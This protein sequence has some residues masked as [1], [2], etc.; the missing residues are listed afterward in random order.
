ME[1]AAKDNCVTPVRGSSDSTAN[2]KTILMGTEFG[3]AIMSMLVVS[4]I[5]IV[6]ASKRHWDAYV[7]RARIR[8]HESILHKEANILVISTAWASSSWSALTI[9]GGGLSSVGRKRA[10]IEVTNERVIARSNG[11]PHCVIN[12]VYTEKEPGAWYCPFMKE[13]FMN[14]HKADID[15]ITDNSGT[16]CLQVRYYDDDGSRI[17]MCFYLQETERIRSIFNN[18]KS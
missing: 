3:L 18:G 17:R 10:D 14:V 4:I 11:L 7:D 15:V 13:Y 2:R 9:T 12:Y 8:P 6:I 16:E 1:R 5:I